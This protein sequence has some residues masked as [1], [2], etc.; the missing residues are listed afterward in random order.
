VEW[1]HQRSGESVNAEF[2]AQLEEAIATR[3]N[4]APTRQV[5]S[6]QECRLC[7]LPASCGSERVEQ[8]PDE[9]LNDHAFF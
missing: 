2:K 9:R 3:R 4:P 8:P 7:D 1:L 5:P 6:F